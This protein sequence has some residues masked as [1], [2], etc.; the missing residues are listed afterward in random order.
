MISMQLQGK[1]RELHRMV[2]GES[3]F[4]GTAVLKEFQRRFG[5]PPNG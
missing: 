3:Q 5:G 4:V 1:V 2:A